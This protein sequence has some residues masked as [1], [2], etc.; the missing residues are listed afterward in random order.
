[1]CSR[2]LVFCSQRMKNMMAI[3]A[4]WRARAFVTFV[5]SAALLQAS[6]AALYGFAT[7][8]WLDAGISERVVGLL[9]AEGVVVEVLL[10][11]LGHRLLR[12]LSVPAIFALA[13][14]A[15]VL[16]WTLLGAS[17][18]LAVLGFAQALHALTFAATHLAAVTHISRTVDSDRTATAQ[19]LYS[20]L[21]MGLVFG[22]AMLAAGFAYQLDPRYAFF[23]MAGLSLG[24]GI[25]A[26]LL[27]RRQRAG[28]A[29]VVDS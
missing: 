16:R 19:G 27:A 6:H 14:T 18:E 25:G 24:G 29:A 7:L 4:R 21:A 11:T 3:L 2:S 10:F 5:C 23:A 20:G 13:A 1:M 28:H 15:G 12:R 22:C 17:T 8:R 9:W 26:L